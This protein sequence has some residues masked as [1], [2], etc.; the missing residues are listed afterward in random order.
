MANAIVVDV[1]C[2]KALGLFFLV[3]KDALWCSQVS[4]WTKIIKGA[5]LLAVSGV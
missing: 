1:A 2:L 5:F 4:T 3:F